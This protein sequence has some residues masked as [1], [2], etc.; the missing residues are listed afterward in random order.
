M[1]SHQIV[2]FLK[3]GA[4]LRFGAFVYILVGRLQTQP[5]NSDEMRLFSPD[6]FIDEGPAEFFAAEQSLKVTVADFEKAIDEYLDGKTADL[7][8]S[9][10]EPQLDDYSESFARIRMAMDRDQLEKAVPVLFAQANKKISDVDKAQMIKNIFRAPQLFQYGCWRGREGILGATPE[11]LVN[12]FNGEL[13]S[14]ALAG[15]EAKKVGVASQLMSHPKERH[16]HDLVVQDIL[17]VLKK[18][19]VPQSRG[20]TLAELPS[21]WHLKTEIKMQ[22][23]NKIDSL[24]VIQLL[25]PT[26]ALG[27]SPRNFGYHWLKNLP[28]AQMR[29]K[30]GAPF[31]ML[32]PNGD[33][34][35][36]VAIRNIQWSQ[37]R[38][39]LGAGGGVVRASQLESEFEELNIKRASVR[40]LM[41]L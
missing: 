36:L 4:F 30:F 41:G 39:I 6:F 34:V 37:D 27:V 7:K 23:T 5:A 8:L 18:F 40:K 13:S 17:S 15:T 1:R 10:Q 21:L 33:L 26:P 12:I 25:H 14:M 24:K 22:L 29:K 32:L 35:S 19:G 16:E 28:Q 11:V 31:A 3:E 38:V 9:W 2:E 20:P